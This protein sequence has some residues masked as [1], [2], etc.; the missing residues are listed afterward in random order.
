MRDATSR[1]SFVCAG[2]WVKTT[3]SSLARSVT[4]AL[5]VVGLGGSLARVSR[6][7]AALQ[8]ALDGAASA[9]AE[10][11]L[12]DLRELDLP[13]YNPDNDQP[14]G[15][16]ARLIEACYSADGMIW[17]S[18]MYQGTISGAFKNALDWLHVLGTRE[19]PFLHDKVIGLISAAGGTQGLQ[20][21]NTMEFATRALRAWDV[22]YVVPVAAAAR[23]FDENGQVQDASVETQLKTL[24]GEVVRVA[25]RFAADSPVHRGS[26]C[27]EAAERVATAA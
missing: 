4:G 17:S 6:S 25:G 12:L 21:I 14:T 22:P 18:P 11:T 7:R 8:S 23:V 15:A 16:A 27:E 20:A 5:T 1:L 26:E 13:M 24:G 9:G 19:P 3:E 2:R 10:T